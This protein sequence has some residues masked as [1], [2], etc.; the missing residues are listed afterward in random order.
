MYK[1][2]EFIKANYQEKIGLCEISAHVGL[3]PSFFQKLFKGFFE[4]TPTQ[5]LL[6]IR[7][8]QAKYQIASTKKNFSTIAKDC[9]FESQTYFNYVFKNTCNMTPKEYRNIV[10]NII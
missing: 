4:V 7:I 10:N 6:N 5:Y 1:A 8:S 2:E 3:S 9:G